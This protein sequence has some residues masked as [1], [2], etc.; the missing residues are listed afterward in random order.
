MFMSDKIYLTRMTR[1]IAEDY[2]KGF[3]VDPAIC[4]DGQPSPEFQY[5]DEW[6]DAYLDRRE[7]D[8]HI[9]VM[10]KNKAVGEI[11]FKR[12]DY[13]NRTAVFSIHLQNDSVKGKG[14]GTIAERL[15]MEY[16]FDILKLNVVYADAIINNT[17]SIH[18]LEKVGFRRVKAAI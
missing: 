7:S 12:T 3:E 15:A 9:A 13:R 10:Y 17:R 1:S 18:V 16:A 14:F 8:V 6:L 11:L 4:L 2:F 5:S